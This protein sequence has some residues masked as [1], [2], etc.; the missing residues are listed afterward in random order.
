VAHGV[1]HVDRLVA[2][3][4]GDAGD[5]GLDGVARGMERFDDD[6]AAFLTHIDGLIEAQLCRFQKGGGDPYGGA[7]APFFYDALHR[8][9]PRGVYTV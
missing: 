4:V 8:R 6:E 2:V 3:F 1:A 5:Q 7:V 9:S